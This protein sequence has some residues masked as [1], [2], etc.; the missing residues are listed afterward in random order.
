MHK[1]LIPALV[2]AALATGS[3]IALAQ[4]STETNP[5]DTQAPAEK[6]APMNDSAAGSSQSG[7]STGMSEDGLK[8]LTAADAQNWVGKRIYS[9]DGSDIGEIQEVQTTG[10]EVKF[11]HA[12]IGGF[13]GLGETRVKIEPSQL[14]MDGEKLVLNMTEAQAKD[15]PKVDQQ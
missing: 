12:D 2:A 5:A 7:M 1:S 14:S 13:L 6:M 15:L 4:T 8:D 11:F 10:E 9:Q 3:T